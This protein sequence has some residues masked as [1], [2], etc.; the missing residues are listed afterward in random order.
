M[1]IRWQTVSES[2]SALGVALN[3]H[4]VTLLL[5]H[6]DSLLVANETMN[7]TAITD[8]SEALRLHVLDSLAAVPFIRAVDTPIADIGTGGGYPGIPIAVSMACAVDLVE[9]VKKKAAFLRAMVETL[10]GLYGSEVFA[11]RAEELAHERPAHYC[12]VVV[13]ALAPL[14]VLVE[15]ASP[16]LAVGGR[17]VA[18]KGTPSSEE[19][20][21]GAAAGQMVGLSEV[22]WNEYA[23][24]GGDRRTVAIYQKVEEPVV[25]L[26]RR[27]GIA[28]KSPLA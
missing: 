6:L 27:P 10:G 20:T 7:L 22:A 18:M 8:P 14:P 13:R 17:L 24:P 21:S 9:V 3:H 25:P 2:A 26:P 16:L 1:E 12:T 23:L 28:Q 19:R 4:Q 15:L 11:H 5:K